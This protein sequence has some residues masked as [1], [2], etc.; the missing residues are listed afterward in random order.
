[1]EDFNT[2]TAGL[3]S[4]ANHAETVTPSDSVDLTTVARALYVGA[5]GD[6]AVL[7]NDDSTATFVGVAA[8]SILPIRVKRVNST[9][10]TATSIVALS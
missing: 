1:M 7:M 9:S 3:D 4:P 5:A 6:V 10:T 2:Y 8:G